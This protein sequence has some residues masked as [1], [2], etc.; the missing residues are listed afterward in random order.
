MLALYPLEEENRPFAVWTRKTRIWVWLR[1]G[2]EEIEELLEEAEMF[3]YMSEWCDIMIK[4]R[5]LYRNQYSSRVE[6][7]E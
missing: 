3:D 6:Q 7:V 1:L 4:Y 2:A 5:K